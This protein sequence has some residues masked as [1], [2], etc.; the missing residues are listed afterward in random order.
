MRLKLMFAAL[1]MLLPVPAL[2]DV[3]ARYALGEKGEDTLVIESDDGGNLRAGVGEKFLLIRRDGVDYI[4]VGDAAGTMK[5]A[6]FDAVL[7]VVSG[8]MK[9]MVGGTDATRMKFVLTEGGPETVAGRAGTI[10]NFGPEEEGGKPGKMLDVVISGD[11]QLAPIGLLFRRM[12]ESIG[13][14]MGGLLGPGNF[15]A[16][17]TELFSKGAPLRVGPVLKLLS[18]D[19]ADVAAS[20]F[21]LPGPVIEPMEWLAAMTPEGSGASMPPLP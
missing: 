4:I 2:A 9:T 18:V 17:G 6:R 14:V 12:V 11:P 5:V 13:P 20:R 3:T 16:L 10:W 7:E 19:T 21:D 15:A 1:L 8:Q